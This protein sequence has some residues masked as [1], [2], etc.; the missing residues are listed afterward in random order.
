[1]SRIL[2]LIT[3]LAL[4]TGVALN[5][6]QA[7]AP[8]KIPAKAQKDLETAMLRIGGG[9]AAAGIA[10]LGE[11]IHRYPT[12]LEPRAALARTQYEQGKKD[13]A[14]QTIEASLAIDTLS[15]LDLLYTLGRLYQETSQ[16]DNAGACY[17]A[18]ARK[19]VHV[20]GLA[21]KAAASLKEL[22][23]KRALTTSNYNLEFIPMQAA[24]NTAAHE[25][26]GRWTLDARQFIFT[27][28]EGEQEDI[29]LAT[30]DSMGLPVK[31]ESWAWNTA[32]NEGAHAISPDGT[33]LIFTAC[34]MPDGRGSC[35]LYMAVRRGEHW[36]QPRNMGA[37][38]NGP[39]WEGQP[40]FGLDGQTLFFSSSQPGGYGG[41]DIWYT[42][43]RAPGK[44]TVPVNAGPSINTAEDEE[45][46]FAHFDGRTLYFMRNAKEGLGG[47]DLYVARMGIDGKWMKAENMGAPINSGADEGALSLH[48]D[49]ERAVITRLTEDRKNDLFIFTLPMKWR[50]APAQ[51]LHVALSDA[52]TGKPI[53]GRVELFEIIDYDTVRLSQPA[54]EQ[55]KLTLML[56]RDS[57]YGLIALADGYYPRSISLPASDA[58]DRPLAIRLEPM[59]STTATLVFENI[60]FESGSAKLLPAAG[61][62]LEQLHKLLSEHPGYHAE[63]RGHTDDVGDVA[64]NQLL[65]EARAK[66]VRDDLVRRG[67]DPVRLTT[68]GF[69]EAQPVADNKTSEG[70]RKNRRTEVLL[71]AGKP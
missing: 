7:Y 62:E 49:G 69:G 21:G 57:E 31:I 40:C 66:A 11:L 54:D 12:W 36:A 25:A 6:Q 45:S 33:Y 26:L 15:Q 32:M 14:I 71:T 27:R 5:A 55:G 38:I 8:P 58:A 37:P 23:S 9:Q 68:I 65:S 30:L 24:I 13:A 43:Q 34:N 61:P 48:P 67:I 17:A 19:A 39:S 63:I 28:K 64:D 59:T 22:E 18:V 70:R 41:R 2:V 35:D 42:T 46:P 60:L 47:Y 56:M 51:A 50:A 44:W 16:W 20:P 52:H 1:L 4:A 29:Y 10:D 53:Q 3:I